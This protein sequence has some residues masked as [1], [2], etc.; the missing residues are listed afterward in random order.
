MSYSF[1]RSVMLDCFVMVLPNPF[2]PEGK[3]QPV[4]KGKVC[5][6]LMFPLL[7]KGCAFH[8]LFKINLL[9]YYVYV[10]CFHIHN[11]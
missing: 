10:V 5:Y 3:G 4:F 11:F 9:F 7:S 1:W 2:L 6:V 8:W